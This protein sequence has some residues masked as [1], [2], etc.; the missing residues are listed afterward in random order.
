VVISQGDVVWADLPEPVGSETGYRRPVVVVQ[1]DRF[2]RSRWR[3]V[4]CVPLTG[5]LDF[6]E[7]PGAVPLPASATGLTRGSVAVASHIVTIDRSL[8]G[9]QVGRIPR[10]SVALLVGAV[11]AV[12]GD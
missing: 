2:N 1:C 6:A 5:N 10:A 9:E 8:L 12:L 4:V 3:T 7:A 11:R